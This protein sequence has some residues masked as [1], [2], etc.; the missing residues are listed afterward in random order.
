M[1]LVCDN[2]TISYNYC[3]VCG[4]TPGEAEEPNWAPKRWWDCDDGWKIGTLCRW[5]FDD[6]GNAKPDPDDYA[7]ADHS[8]DVCTDEPNTDLDPMLA[9][10]FVKLDDTDFVN[11]S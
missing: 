8:G 11:M 7:Y 5:C 9:L 10:S 2:A 1:T 3:G 6:V 4:R